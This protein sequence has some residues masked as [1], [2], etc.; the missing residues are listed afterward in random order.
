L[1]GITLLALRVSAVP[2]PAANTWSATGDLVS[3]RAGA[4][5]A[6]MYNGVVLV[7]GGTT[8]AGVV[9]T[10]ERYNPATGQFIATPPM[11]QARANHAST[12]LADG[13]V[14]V[15]GGV[16]VDGRALASA[17][18]YDPSSN[19]WTV[20]ASMF[21][22]RAGHTATMLWDERIL[23]A[24][25][26]DG[27]VA[28]DWLEIFDPYEGAG[29][30]SLMNVVLTSP[31]T[32]HAAT[33]LYKGDVLVA[34]GFNG[35]NTLASID[36]IDPYG[37][38][39]VKGPS[40]VIPRAGLTATTL[41]GGKVLLLGGANDTTELATAK[42]YDPDANTLS[43]VESAMAVPRQRHSAILLPHNNAVLIVGGTSNGAAA[44]SAELYVPW[45]GNGGTFYP[46]NAPGAARTWAMT[47]P[48]SFEASLTIRTGPNDGLMLLAGGSASAN[49]ANPLKSAEL[50]HFATVNTDKADYPPFTTVHITGGG[51]VPGE[52][53]RL[54]FL[55]TGS[56][57]DYH[58]AISVVADAEGKIHTD[59]FKTDQH[60]FKMHFLLTATGS[61]SQVQ[62]AFTDGP[63][64]KLQIL[65]PGESNDPMQPN[66]K[67]GSPTAQTA[68]TPVTVTV[69]AV[70][71]SYNI[72]ASAGDVVAI[73]SSDANATLPANAALINGTRTFSVTFKTGGNQTVTA[74]DV[75]DGTK[76][77]DTGTATAVNAG[78]FA[79]LLILLPGQS[80][81]PGTATGKSGSATA[82]V[83][84]TPF[85]VTVNAVDAN[86]NLT[87]TATDTVAITSS[88]AQATL[89]ANAALVAGTQTF[90][91]TLK[92]SAIA[93]GQNVTASDATDGSKTS[94]TGGVTV[95]AA[96]FSKLLVKLP[97]QIYSGSTLTG[98]VTNQSVGHSFTVTVYAVDAYNNWITTAPAD[99]IQITSSD[100]AATLPANAALA[101]GSKQFTVTLNTAGTFTISA[102]DVTNGG[103][104]SGTSASVI[105]VGAFT[106]L[107][108]LMPGET[109]APNTASGKT[110]TPTA[111]TAGSSFNVTV[112][113]VDANWNVA[114]TATDTVHLA[115]SDAN[116]TLAANGALS[117]GTRTMAVTFKTAGSQT[118]TVSDVTSGSI[119]A[120]TSAATTVNAG[121]VTRLQ[122]LMP[123]E[124]ASPGSTYGKTGTPAAQTAGT[125]F[126]VTVNAVDAN[127]N[128]VNTVTD[129][130]A[131][132][133]NDA[134]AVLPANAALVA[135]TQTFS[136]TFETKAEAKNVTATD[137]TN[138]SITANTGSN[139]GVS[140]GA[141]TKL[142]ILM[143]GE[144]AAG[145]TATGKTG[146][147]TAETAGT[148]FNVTVN[149]VDAYWN[150]VSTVTDT[151]GLSTTD[152]NAA[153][154]ASGALASGTKT[155]TVTFK[156]AGSQTVTISDITD[157]SKTANT[158][159]ST[160]V[161]AGAYSKLQ[162][163]MPGET[164]APG[165]VSGKTGS[166]TAQTAGTQFT[167]TVNSVDANWNV[168]ASDTSAITF[169]S[170]DANAV[171]PGSTNL[172]AGTLTANV[173]FKTAGSG[174][175]VTAT[176]S[177][178]GFAG[179]STVVNNAGFSKL[180][181]LVPGESS[182][183]GTATGK[184][185]SPTSQT[186]GTAF[187]ANVYAV[188][189]YWNVVGS[190]PNDSIAITS[191]DSNATLPAN[192]NLAS[193]FKSFSV[194]LK[195]AGS[196]TVTASDVTDGTKTPSTSSTVTL[197]AGTATKLQ[198]LMPG[199]TAA[200]GTAS[201]KTGTP[202]NQPAS[203]A[204]S[205]VLVNAVDANWNVVS[206]VTHTVHFVSTDGAATLP[207]D[208]ALVNGTKS[209]TVTLNT[210]GSQTVTVSDTVSPGT[211]TSNTSAGVQVTGALNKL[212]VLM[213]GET[214][215]QGSATG[216]SGSP[217]A[218]IAGAPF[219]VMVYGVDSNYYQVTTASDNITLKT[220][221][222]NV[223]QT[224][225]GAL[226]NGAQTYSVT[227][228]TPGNQTVTAA[229]FS[230]SGITAGTGSAT[231]VTVGAYYGLLLLMPG[232][233]AAPA[234]IDGKTGTPTTQTAGLPF[235]VTVNAVDASYNLVN[236][237]TDTVAITSSDGAAALPANAA[238][239]GGTGTFSVTMVTGTT[240]FGYRKSITINGGQIT[241]TL[242]N[243]P[244]SFNS[245][246]PDFKSLANGGRVTNNNGYDIIFRAL[247]D[248]T[249]GGAGTSPCTL[250]H[251]IEKYDPV[252]GQV[253]AWVQVPSIAAGTVIY[254]YYGNGAITAPTAA[255]AGVWS[256]SYVGVWHMGDGT[257]LSSTDSTNN[258]NNGTAMNGP[259]AAAGQI[260]GGASLSSNNSQYITIPEATNMEFGTGSFAYSLWM[261][262]SAATSGVPLSGTSEGGYG[263]RFWTFQI[264]GNNY[265]V[266]AR[267]NGSGGPITAPTTATIVNDGNWHHIAVV[268]D[269]SNS[270]EHVYIDGTDVQ[271]N[272]IAGGFGSVNDL[273]KSLTI[274]AQLLMEGP[275][276]FMNYFNGSLDEVRLMSGAPSSAWVA[277]EYNNQHAPS[278][279]YALGAGAAQPQQLMTLSSVTASDASDGS[280]TNYTSL[281]TTVNEGTFTQLQI[282]LPGETA[283]PGSQAG[284]SGTALDQT[285]NAPFTVTVNAV[286]TN[287]NLVT[288]ATD[289]IAITSSDNSAT[290]PSN[291]ALVS[292][293]RTFN[294]TPHSTGT[295]TVTATDASDGSK[296]AS[297][298][299]S[300][301]VN[302]GRLA[303]T[304]QPG[305][306][307][308]GDA[309][310]QQPVVTVQDANGNTI[311]SNA[312]ITLAIST[313]PGNGAL[314]G[315]VTV[316]AVNGVATFTNVS[317]NVAA[318]GYK[319]QAT[320]SGLTATTSNAF[321]ITLGS[322]SKLAFTTSPSSSRH[323]VAFA[324][325]P[326][327]T[328][329]DDGGNT[330]T[331]NSSSIT[332]AIGNNAG[333]GTLSGTLT[334]SAVN[335][336]ATFTG[337]SIDKSGTGYTLTA[338]SGGL[339]SATSNVF[340][341][342][343]PAMWTGAVN[344]L[345]SNAGNWTGLA[346]AAPSAG[347][348]L[349]FPNGASNL[350]TSNDLAASTSINSITISGSGYTLAGNAI[351]LVAGITDSTAAGSN[352]I[353]LGIATSTTSFGLTTPYAETINVANA[354]ETLTISGVISGAGSL[355]TSGNGTL[356]LNGSNT[357]LGNTTITAGTLKVT[358]SASAGTSGTTVYLNGGTLDFCCTGA[359]VPN[360]I[361]GHKLS[362][363]GGVIAPEANITFSIGS[364][365]SGAG[366]LILNGAGTLT[367]TTASTFT[368]DVTIANGTLQFSA[369]NQL[370]AAANN[371]ILNGGSA[372]STGTF[373][374]ARNATLNGGQLSVTG[375]TT[376]WT[377]SGVV[378]GG[379]LTMSGT[380]LLAL[381]GTNTYTGPV[382]ITNGYL[383][384]N[385]DASLGAVPANATPGS[386]VFNGGKLTATS[387]TVTINSNRGIQLNAAAT[388]ESASP[389]VVTYG[390]VIVGNFGL[391]KA[392]SGSLTLSGNNTYTGTTTIAAGTL[393][394]NGSQ[395]QSNVNFSQSNSTLAGTGTV[396]NITTTA[397]TNKVTP[398]NSGA[399]ILNTSNLSGALNYTLDIN[400]AVAGSGY[401]QLNVT[402][403]VNLTG[404]SLG[405]A[406]GGGY[407]PAV[408]TQF[409]IIN[410]DGA[411]AITGTFTGLA[412]GATVTI[413][414]RNFTISYV[415][416]TGNDVVLTRVA[417]PAS[418]YVFSTQP[419]G[420]AGGTAFTTQP[421]VTVQ[422]IDGITVTN[423]NA[424][425]TLS[426]GVNPSGGALSGTAT[427]NAVNGVATFTNLS[428]DKSGNGYTLVTP[429][430]QGQSVASSAFNVG[431]GSASK[432]VFTTS[433]SSSRYNMAFGTQPVVIVQ[434]AGG[435]TVT[436]SSASITAAIGT[437]P[438]GGALG[439]TA[440]VNAVNGVA[441]FSGLS[442][443]LNGTGY[444]LT[445][446]SAGLTGATS[447]TFNITGPATW[448]GAV[449][450]L[451]SVA[452]NWSGLSG[453][454]P[455]AGEDLI[456]PNGASNLSNTNDIAAGTSF[457]SITFSGNGY[458]LAG[459]SITL[460]GPVN[461]TAAS[462]NNAI[463]LAVALGTTA[464]VTV[465]NNSETLTFYGV[466]SGNFGLT[467]TGSGIL[468]PF[469]VNTFTGNV[470]MSAGTMTIN[471]DASMGNT[472]NTLLLNGGQMKMADGA[473]FA[474]VRNVTLGGGSF[475]LNSATLTMTT[476]IM[477]GSGGL[478]ATGPGTLL[479]A[480]GQSTFTGGVSVSSGATV[481]VWAPDGYLSDTT[482]TVTLNNGT[483]YV[484]GTSASTARAFVVG[485]GGGSA[486]I[487]TGNTLTLSGV[488]SGTGGLT[489]TGAGTLL[490]SNT[491]T[492]TGGVGATAGT[493]S[494]GADANLGDAT[495]AVT[496]NNGS[497]QT[498]AT[499][500][501]AR[502]FTL[503][504]TGTIAP[505]NGTTLTLS[506][507]LSGTGALTMNGAGTLVPSGT[508]TYSGATT[509]SAG[510]LQISSDANLG[511]APSSPTAGQL[512]LS[513]TTL[514]LTA[515][516]TLNANRGVAITSTSTINTAVAT[517]LTYNGV[518]AGAGNLTKA[519]SG[520]LALGGT[521]TYTGTTNI[522]NY[523]LIV[524]GS[525]ASS[526]TTLNGGTLIGA[527]TV[528]V[529]STSSNSTQI[530]A[531]LGGPGILNTGNLG[532][533]SG[534][535]GATVNVTLNGTTAGTGYS[536]IN[537]TG[538]V[539][540][541]GATLSA[542]LGGGFTPTAGQ[543]FNIIN[544]DG[545]DAVTGTFAGLA[546]GASLTIG[547]RNFTI[548]YA[549]GTGNDV[550]LTS[551]AGTPTKVAFTT[552][553][554][555]ATG[556]VAFGTQPVATIQDVDGN[557]VTS[558]SAAVTL[559]IGTNP[560]SGTLSGT[561]TVNAVNGVA[562]LSGLS[563]DQ[564]GTG[565]TLTASATGVTGAT[566]NSFNVVAGAFA[567]LQIL[568]PGET[569]A[570]GTASG[571][572][573]TPNAQTA[574]SAFNVTVNAVDANWNVVSSTDTVAITSSDTNAVLPANAALV[575]GTATFSVNLKTAGTKTVTASD[576]TNGAITANTSANTTVNAGAFVKL[577]LIAPGE[578][579]APGTPTGKSGTPS[580]VTSGG[581]GSATAYAVDAN[582]NTVTTATDTVHLVST[583]PNAVL[584]INVTLVAGTKNLS[585]LLKTVGSQTMT[586]SDVT[587]NTKT[588][589]TSAT[590][591]VV[592]GAFTKL[593]ILMPGE[594]ASPGSASGKTGSP[595]A[596]TAGSSF[597][598]TVN[599]VD[600]NWNVV[601]TAADTVAITSSD[602]NA[603]LP[604][605][606]ALVTG[607]RTFSVT[608]KTAGTKTVTASDAS[609]ASI[610]ANT[611]P[612]TTVNA[613]AF[614]KLQ[615]LMPG[616]TASA[617]SASGKTGSSSAQTAGSAF[618][619]TVNGVDANWNVVSAATDTVA[620]TSS[621]ANATLPAN[622]A[623]VAGTK[624]FSVTLN[625]VGSSIY[626]TGRT[627]TATDATDGTK[628]ANTSPATTVNAGAFAKLQILM[629]GESS[630]PGTASGKTGTPT[631]QTA[632]T[633]FNVTVNA[634]DAN[635]NV[636]ST[637]TDTIAITSSDA[638]ATLPAN[639]ALVAGTKTFSV[640]F[641]T[642]GTAT[643]T[644]SDATDGTKTPNTSPNVTVNAG[645]FVKLQLLLPGE[646]SA[647]GTA[648]GKTGAP[649]AQTAGSA[650]NVSVNAVDANWN[651]VSSTDTVAI[652]SSDGNATLPANAALVAGTRTLSVT[653]K[654][655]GTATVTAT[656]VTDGTKTANTSPLVT[657]NTSAATQLVVT[658]QPANTTAGT[659][660]SNVVL[661]IRDAYNNKVSGSAAVSLAIAT[662]P[663]SGTLSG[664]ATVNAVAGVATLSTLSID[665]AGTGYTLAASSAGLSGATSS[666]F[667][668]TVG[669]AAQ[670]A[671]TTAPTGAVVSAPLG[672]QPAVTVQDVNGNTVTSSS[673]AV[674]V[675]IG[676]NLSSGALSGT[677]TVIAVNGVATFSGLNINKVG[678]GY[679]L[680]AASGGLAGATSPAFNITPA[681]TTITAGSTS[682]VFGAAS[683]TLSA[684][685]TAN[686]PSTA[687]VSEGTVTFTVKDGG[688]NTV[689]SPTTSGTVSAGTAT[690]TFSLSGVPAGSYSIQA[691]YNPANA[692]PNFAT[693]TTAS[694]GT[695][696]VTKAT[697]TVT[698][699]DKS[700]IYGAANPALTASYSGFVNGDT[701]AV[702][703]GAPALS[704]TATSS[705]AAGAYAITAA[706]GTLS[707]S[708]YSFAFVNGTLT[709]NQATVTVTAVDK[710]KIYG[711][712]NPALTASYSGFV[713][714]DTVAVLSGAPSLSTAVTAST[715]V[716]AYA[717]TAAQ[718]TLSASN[719]SFAFAN[720][721]LTVSKATLTVT[722]DHQT[723]I[724]GAPNPAL[725][726]S[727]S[728]FVNGD[729]SA[730]VNGTPALS[731]TATNN[732]AIGTYPITA[733][734]GSLSASNYS[735][736]FVNGTLMVAVG[737]LTV[738]ADDLSKVYGAANP[739]LTVSYSG[740]V[741][742][743][744]ASILSG[745]PSL[746]TTAT[747]GSA[748]GT[749]PIAA[750][751]GTLSAGNYALAFVNGA[752]TVSKA[753]LTITAVDQS[754]TYGAPNPTLTASYNGF[755]N[756]DTVASLT[757]AP[758]LATTATASSGV[759]GYPI[760]V[761]LG[762]LA[763]PNY[764]FAFVNGTFT[765]STASLTVTAN[766]LNKAYGAPNPALTVT[767]SGF[768][769]GETVASLSGALSLSTTA[770][771]MS[772]A[773]AYPI[774]IGQGTL[775]SS[776]YSL[777]F[778]N[779]TLTIGQLSSQLVNASSQTIVYGT[780]FVTVNGG[781]QLGA[782]VPKPSD[783]V[784]V[785][786]NGVQ[787]HVK[788]QADGTF[789]ASFDT[790][791]LSVV[792]SPYTISM[793]YAG[794][795]DLAAA[796]DLTH[797]LTVTP[798]PLTITA[799][800]QTKVAGDPNPSLTV[801]YAG[802]INGDNEKKSLSTPPTVTTIAT[803]SS[804]AGSYRIAAIG[805]VAPDYAITYM[806]GTL[807]V[808][809]AAASTSTST[810]TPTALG[811][812]SGGPALPPPTGG[813]APPPV[814]PDPPA[815][816]I[817]DTKFV[818]PD[819]SD[820]DDGLVRTS[821]DV[822]N[823]DV[824]FGQDSV[825]LT[826]TVTAVRPM[827]KGKRDGDTSFAPGDLSVE[828]N[829]GSVSFTVVNSDGMPVRTVMSD[830]V[831]AGEAVAEISLDGLP[832]GKY[833][834]RTAY[835]P[836]ADAKD[837]T[838]S[839][840]SMS[841]LVV[842]Q[843]ATKVE[844][845][846]SRNPSANG[847]T[848]TF[849]ATVVPEAG[850][851]PGG[852]VSFYL[853]GGA[854][855]IGTAPVRLVDG[856]AVATFT[857]Q[858]FHEGTHGVTAEYQGDEGFASSRS[859]TP[860]TQ[861]VS[862]AALINVVPSDLRFAVQ[863]VST[864][865]ASLAIRLSNIG[866]ADLPVMV[867][868]A[869]PNA[870]DFTET[871]SCPA[872]LGYIAPTNAC[873]ILVTFHPSASGMR[874][875]D[876][877]IL[878]ADGKPQTLPLT[879]EGF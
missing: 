326:V 620:I 78:A 650:F 248:T 278:S 315:T 251:E 615:I 478:M 561:A 788:L 298:S 87:N 374:S 599:A 349:V 252:A 336:V 108:I 738:T 323:G 432:L 457:N 541:T 879:G 703:S 502:A 531:A 233:T 186:A 804:P 668:I 360:S 257:T 232:E 550:V 399:G 596:Q 709:I 726:A 704:T 715:A 4:S 448:T 691:T 524:T 321:N 322:A 44:A 118:V 339:T 225:G 19:S 106:K 436:N 135:G 385:T 372:T 505:N 547:G 120:N 849:T 198:I 164:A 539:N 85:N 194:I 236:T 855:P 565:Y 669:A 612:N 643:V 587:D 375:G 677:T 490:L 196:R 588:S 655:A 33:L 688:N 485:A 701:V 449:S 303:F 92:S 628:T 777:T 665:K 250:H 705:S 657:V 425:I 567:K 640:T 604:A 718:G 797:L 648:S 835:T 309:W 81:A 71:A 563:I 728:G 154:G 207:F 867:G 312:A 30:F 139:V 91:V 772:D 50:Y 107:Q 9:A 389:A 845:A 815:P 377:V 450:N 693:S 314:G 21:R 653:L 684:T 368:G 146:T 51:W 317:I 808:Q 102:S 189:A 818:A 870:A 492:F 611:S 769:N 95:N 474:T 163:L 338:S 342:T 96:A 352:T 834:I 477:S 706:Q 840:P 52:S 723:K 89:P 765:I 548:S 7:V 364:A 725:T 17:E 744:T 666:A 438:G 25:G 417:G 782:Y 365:I 809:P 98:T 334:V 484:R 418:G 126:N 212:L 199:E 671:L 304:T 662:N 203:H 734:A 3:A 453:G 396:G 294:V 687:T 729:T 590:I 601:S 101:T 60:D 858:V 467:K 747:S 741:N 806:P 820:V 838:P 288:T 458:T 177:N 159:P 495:N 731:T 784:V 371:I 776:N 48:L 136:V 460:A 343:G 1:A 760:T 796:T 767:Y 857:T 553:P 247:D 670:L 228:K 325:Q 528:G 727:Y 231:S 649:T 471:S 84:G 170:T 470:T 455:S 400:G 394:V 862:P 328:V 696:T 195:T 440:T 461:D 630:A 147:P 277:A 482:N 65:M 2:P 545:N 872:T 575:A 721:T 537:V 167:L 616:E 329:Q 735:F 743:D 843:S 536:Q 509:V 341:I 783:E 354:A 791:Q 193:G 447:S 871:T 572:T 491:N 851:K 373:T 152:S 859:E 72:V 500:S 488:I 90:S 420:A 205:S 658:T 712:A 269:R 525:L 641:K 850:G 46:T 123:G 844:L 161:N 34:G 876:L 380:G 469:G 79:K 584:N 710:S 181:V 577:L 333:G 532:L 355:T 395:G 36:I 97:G 64:A 35:A 268:V 626:G 226:V 407:A 57:P 130:V 651:V 18:A 227:L 555:G 863:R 538:T 736:S 795:A 272:V 8:N 209:F 825:T 185:G 527:G 173:T 523:R 566:S 707:A 753:A 594:T 357:Y 466:V 878:D 856:K 318:T 746:V 771:T 660:M 644:A 22:A 507:V 408:G 115:S 824:A 419:S 176:K 155:M 234:T 623:L 340:S 752:L 125:P 285:L 382:T 733:A 32:G 568:M 398:G 549:G 29:A 719:Y 406:V 245:T 320:G 388:I 559:A 593:Q 444:T 764:S 404:A 656:D 790:K 756:G 724:Y 740:F 437:N 191:N 595:T 127:W 720:G 459:N 141:F 414:N 842:R 143:P 363:G 109:A 874:S 800:N 605:N 682:G 172:A 210:Q 119:T 853:D 508:N 28:T 635:W 415:G 497:L 819:T 672:T 866:D 216:K 264:S 218:Q 619:V 369:D 551:I 861:K 301:N 379:A 535:G 49:A 699:V 74:T 62:T 627:V 313:N 208:T 468:R 409:T 156:T 792:G 258:A 433:P 697:L 689:G 390:G 722:A 15:T 821:T 708:N 401:D 817:V 645:A 271:N 558:S 144:T 132:T 223:A 443:S 129:T 387:N 348:D 529:V 279:F 235:N 45:Q 179:A 779:G 494:V 239:V 10:A 361:F 499:F 253:V 803:A 5:A 59:D 184:S 331:S 324:T 822:A 833:T 659:T 751:Q 518:I 311:N 105:D 454:A 799:D 830:A 345:W 875:A 674:T 827:P 556:S 316:N 642:A 579:Y 255:P 220:S 12:L 673:A 56:N 200:P 222:T 621:D 378:S 47:V 197:N 424:A 112:N 801:T 745:T 625:T 685:V 839:K 487:G 534:G 489:N 511:T 206:S 730:V 158:S 530:Q 241:G 780:Q 160:T 854:I 280:K 80:A 748:V 826:A 430:P 38:T 61:A 244:L 54:T 475:F 813:V 544:N 633:S 634:V 175:T 496:L 793:T 422:D 168:V 281:L 273:Y 148:V 609:N 366:G 259:T 785:T 836:G 512:T 732:S 421:V 445:A 287:W 462:G 739:A 204:F 798:A 337:L 877:T 391:T 190:A 76:T 517:T 162:V 134:N 675:A 347:E 63:F 131:I 749:Y 99:T 13:R 513:G 82:Q 542:S 73:T 602:A 654:T 370:G 486:Y 308:G 254:V 110:G 68:G 367:L 758:A 638:S 114:T 111:Q 169:T 100:G 335:G 581:G 554:A 83:A 805:A 714:G 493:I 376:T 664:T 307:T 794:N 873:T 124:S 841:T 775:T 831:A 613:G 464:T 219:N 869:G 695:L 811:A 585:F 592:A 652:T 113:A 441:T 300:F 506:G 263:F 504:N 153:L 600:A 24:G 332:I 243:F 580:N 104:G 503:T 289:T 451:W 383:S 93:G 121:A 410:N 472:A 582:W 41:L 702:L 117:S 43:D 761:A 762:T 356:L 479:L 519:G 423:S 283:A 429:G 201:G 306:G 150:V 240:T 188:D 837:L 296:T 473:S 182:A 392:G 823:A 397:N 413:S 221:D 586:V 265:G 39:V 66:G 763:S 692:S 351:V 663:G 480:V 848:T 77:P 679:T 27:G 295:F 299:T 574:G 256:N 680:T 816:P 275:N 773:G 69:N 750:T 589:S 636:A 412:E 614:A 40:M 802:F 215:S 237:V 759:G 526:N 166:P 405:G 381:T 103:I 774:T 187:S 403:T 637:A 570:P 178:S 411:D 151:V 681:N 552:Q 128:V 647:P 16:G 386:I 86:W 865:S 274:G 435:N 174:K 58:P 284:K 310:A 569:A 416:G 428:I 828:V 560:A 700:K 481:N 452:G 463:N 557:T 787:K 810:T 291:A 786:L 137:I 165:T 330:V 11:H 31:R 262:T 683:V 202:T 852:L 439:G 266:Q 598:V 70:D 465:T 812:P 261:K 88:D 183:P 646:S 149:A 297:T 23:I 607:T 624:T 846:S 514:A 94:N 427:V 180:M 546:E 603:T 75:T 770:T 211:L 142:Q 20:L 171:L 192:A 346:G 754:K 319:L 446:A 214:L 476:G 847:Q 516:L 629:P 768:V 521:N 276:T 829:G 242:T 510:T 814:V 698:A 359:P 393:T 678:N 737:T 290:L 37:N 573:G 610:T 520:T 434:D 533:N 576:V 14:L 42:L 157:G 632:G 217:T 562:T 522:G 868:I 515:D 344:N 229:D 350:S 690:A 583:D 606:A 543:T 292:G 122:V 618:N 140:A 116:A 631:A 230:N 755:V 564:L 832:V 260:G 778:V 608:L 807:T 789:S 617:G 498:T 578:S 358:A 213:P 483:L 717:I 286:G 145:G 302:G 456:F 860:F 694:A 781:L 305:G 442:V 501:S 597:N 402:G 26:D 713:N 282:L 431:V 384:I 238:L 249:C 270:Q 661:E 667:N 6:L 426:L 676:T 327:V 757:G 591:T 540:L 55:E 53:V 293:A 246:D 267:L 686:A 67:S 138:G 711:A 353:S 224:I 864:T 571:K 622:A 133:S 742:G 639:A 716:G 766:S 362:V